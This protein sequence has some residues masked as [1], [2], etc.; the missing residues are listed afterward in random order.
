MASASVR[1]L[2]LITYLLPAALWGGVPAAIQPLYTGWMFV[3]AAGYLTLAYFLFF[4]VDP[5][6]ARVGGLGF[7]LFNVLFVLILVPSALWMPWTFAYLAE[8][9]ALMWSVVR[10]GLATTGLAALGMI[11]A[12]VLLEPREPAGLHKAAVAGAIGFFVQTG[13][14]DA[15]LWPVW[16]PN[17]HGG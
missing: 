12:L 4:K 15:L 5:E 9:S 2:D 3:A 17:L 14:L 8:P 13:V 10:A 11:A 1:L 16:F 7:G 6:R